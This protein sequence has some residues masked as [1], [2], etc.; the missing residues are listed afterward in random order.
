MLRRTSSLSPSFGGLRER[1]CP[2][3]HREVD[4]P[5]GTLCDACRLEIERRARR[6]ARWVSLLTTAAFGVYAMLALPYDRTARLVGAA[7]TVTWY[8]VVRRGARRGA[9]EWF[10]SR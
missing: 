9:R 8:V 5:L 10:A 2:R 1:E 6:V 3:C 4:L 7:A